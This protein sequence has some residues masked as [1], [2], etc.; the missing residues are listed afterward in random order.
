MEKLISEWQE[1]WN[2]NKY[3]T[4]RTSLI[5]GVLLSVIASWLVSS[6][7]NAPPNIPPTANDTHNEL[8]APATDTQEVTV[9][10]TR[11]GSKYHRGHCRYLSRSKSP[12]SLNDARGRYGPCSVCGP[13][14]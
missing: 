10:V 6:W 7:F 3:P 14:R 1:F 8:V 9:Y 13:P 5:A 12:M 4:V 2:D 11:T